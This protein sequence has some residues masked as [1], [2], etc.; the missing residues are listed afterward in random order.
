MNSLKETPLHSV[1]LSLDPPLSTHGFKLGEFCFR[2][3]RTVGIQACQILLEQPRPMSLFLH[4]PRQEFLL[5][6]PHIQTVHQVWMND[7]EF[8]DTVQNPGFDFPPHLP[9]WVIFINDDPAGGC[10][11]N[12]RQPMPG[13]AIQADPQEIEAHAVLYAERTSAFPG[14][15]APGKGIAERIGG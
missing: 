8:R 3:R 9:V 13:K 1:Q 15:K 2:L 5:L 4:Q 11:R 6:P 12:P 10:V 14:L 7:F